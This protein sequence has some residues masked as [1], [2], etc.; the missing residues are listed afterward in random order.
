MDVAA[1]AVEDG[2][3]SP[4]D[5]IEYVR[6]DVHEM[7]LDLVPRFVP[8]AG[9]H[10]DAATLVPVLEGLN[11]GVSWRGASGFPVSADIDLQLNSSIRELG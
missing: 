8:V 1:G 11:V 5:L 2:E 4:E 7:T 10:W 9:F 6:V 3:D